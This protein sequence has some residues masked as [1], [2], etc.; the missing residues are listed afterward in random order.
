MNI[1]IPLGGLGERFKNEGYF[2]P[3]PLV[4]ILGKEMLFYLIDNLTLCAE[5]KLIIIYNK[6]LDKFNFK[7]LIQSKYSKSAKE[8]NNI[9]VDMITL[10][11]NTDGAAETILHGLG[12]IDSKYLSRKTILLDCDTFYFSDVITTFRNQ[13]NCSVFC[14][15][16]DQDKP[17]YSYCK[18]ENEVVKEIKEKIK[19][20]EYA[21]TGCYCF[22]SGSILKQYCFRVV[23]NN[24]KERGEFYTSCV[25][26]EMLKDGYIFNANVIEP[27]DFKCVGTPL[28]LKIFCSYVSNTKE[29][30]NRML[31]ICFDL[32]NTLVTFPKIN[33]DY[34]T[35][36]PITR[37]I[38]YLKYL[39]KIGHTIIIY[40]ARRMRTYNG[41]VAKVI[42]NIGKTTFDTL[43]KF[44]IPYD[45]IYFGKPHADC[46]IDDLA[47][48]AFADIEKEI[49]IYKTGI[50][51]RD[52][53]EI[54]TDTMD[55]ITKKSFGDKLK[56]EI[57]YY[58]NMPTI[59]KKYFPLF[60]ASGQHFYSMEKIKGIP[61]SYL[62]VNESL[63]RDQF[64]K[65]LNIIHE[66]H[67]VRVKE[68]D[69][70][71]NINIYDVYSK[72]ITN[73]YN[74]F[75]YSVYP[76]SCETYEKLIRYFD[77]Y[78]DESG[79]KLGI[80]HGDPVLTNCIMDINGDFKLID[81]RGQV[82]EVLTI[83]GDIFYDYGKIFQSITG[84]DEI[85]LD[86]IINDTYK[87]NIVR[88]F[89]EFIVEKYG[90]DTMDKIKMIRDSLLFTL[91]PLHHNDKC[92]KYYG[93]INQD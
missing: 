78:E 22:E 2:Q 36:E 39:K 14:F 88:V 80:I 42:T 93:W 89:R 64:S 10:H 72:K 67:N 69:V 66:I 65:F 57:F 90:V 68:S 84:Y 30:N 91:I 79:G 24:I 77:T 32:D 81:M 23:N 53:N 5:D 48:N 7:D 58:Q 60:I 19:I 46:Y 87:K 74:G 59:I 75:D 17:I 51:E 44:E 29:N 86:K 12:N 50:S 43:D 76:H 38:D 11:K 55:V 56:G 1:I 27:N 71:G 52:F 25:I 8:N 26:S 21:N 6:E 15:R 82:G 31:R 9:D 73:R 62:Y 4:K 85:L 61:L 13:S 54:T 41:N 18:I 33:G 63:T 45:E 37:N 70:D 40:T 47:I 3:K 16:D 35:V 49:G 34:S 20:S 92:A 28:Q 83:Y